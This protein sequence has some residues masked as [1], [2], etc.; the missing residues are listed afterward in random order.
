MPLTFPFAEFSSYEL[1][2]LSP[3]FQT[4]LWLASGPE[5]AGQLSSEALFLGTPAG[6]GP[7]PQVGPAEAP[8]GGGSAL[9]VVGGS[10]DLRRVLFI[11][12]SS[13]LGE[14]THLWSGDKTASG[15][16]PSL[17]EYV[18]VGNS[19]PRLVGISNVGIPKKITDSNLISTCGTDLGG[20]EGDAYNAVSLSGSRVF[21]TARAASACAGTG[22]LVNEVYART[23]D[24]RS[25]DISE[26]SKADCVGCELSTPANAEFQGASQDGSK[27][28]FT[29]SQ[30][31]L[32]GATGIGQNLY[33]Y[34][35]NAPAEHR[36]TRI[37][38]KSI[39]GDGEVLGV[40]RVSEDGSHVYFV[41]SES[42]S[43]AN[44]EGA[45]PT[46]GLPNLYVFSQECAAGA[47]SCE[48]PEERV[49]FIATLVPGETGDESDW[50]ARD[51]RPAQATTDGRF[52]AFESSADLTS[53]EEG[54]QEAGQIFEYDAREGTLTRVSRGE[55]GF[56]ENGN[57]NQYRA[58]IHVQGYEEDYDL[59]L[60]RYHGLAIST[61]GSVFFSSKDALTPQALSGFVNIYEYHDGHVGLISDGHDTASTEGFPA[62]E[63]IGTDESGLDVFFMTADRL[64]PQDTDNQVDLY[65]ARAGGGFMPS[66]TTAGCLGD[67]CQAN[68]SPPPP[69]LA[70]KTSTVLGEAVAAAS[71]AK[72]SAV[73]HKTKAKAKARPKKRKRRPRKHKATHRK[74]K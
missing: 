53:D 61:D 45:S 64:V 3:T 46:V 59:L 4:G 22:P 1:K 16:L 31:L 71:P 54:R 10:E 15:H 17:Y 60:Q 62:V 56:G 49:S 33:E 6:P 13:N 14:P 20:A 36:L 26:P 70:A 50:S 24:G 57:S 69:L 11:V 41:A 39:P 30:D 63:L 52:L 18:G 48:H 5:V 38:H 73:K 74:R 19:E 28:F 23:S 32:S 40:V 27:V 55:E 12:E 42:L 47:A 58:S 66:P 68:A 25:V 7:L 35:F 29:T 72:P 8:T 43:G 44:R 9:R 65:D 67:S 2:L 51:A 21:F 37:S 34:D